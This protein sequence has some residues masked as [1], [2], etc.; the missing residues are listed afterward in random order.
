MLTDVADGQP[1]SSADVLS[2]GQLVCECQAGSTEAFGGL[3]AQ[4]HERIFNF[5]LKLTGQP[6]DAE[7]ITQET[8]LKAWQAIGRFDARFSFA[9]WLF[10]I[11]KRTAYSHLRG[12][13]LVAD[14]ADVPE[15]SDDS[16]PASNLSQVEE[17]REL[18][19]WARTLKPKQY[20]ALWLCYG[21]G[22]SLA[23]TAKIMGLHPIHARVLLHRGRKRLAALLQHT[24]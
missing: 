23:E 20:Q 22:C 10:T 5:V 8:F 16:D 21:E 2:V 9:T 3:V 7:D 6:H 13:R 24:R 19:R 4:F 15:P 18:W 17:A 11:A 1:E 12:R 14:P